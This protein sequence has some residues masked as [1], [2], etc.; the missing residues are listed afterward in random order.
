M[1]TYI[2]GIKI[3]EIEKKFGGKEKEKGKERK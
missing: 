3:G 1:R 2:L